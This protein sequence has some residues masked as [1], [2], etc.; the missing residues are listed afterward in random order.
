VDIRHQLKQVLREC[1]AR[2]LYHSG[3]HRLLDRLMPRRLLVLAGHCV[4]TPENASLGP[5]MRIGAAK[6]ERILSWFAARYEVL[7]LGRA[8]ERLEQPGR[9]S[10]VA[11]TMDDGYRDNRTQLLPLLQRL[12]LSATVYLES[13]PLEERRP[14]WTHKF[15][16]T[17]ERTGAERYAQLFTERSGLA[18]GANLSAYQLKRALKYEAPVALRTRI[19]DELFREQ[20]GD[21]RAL[22]EQLYLDWSQVRE[23]DRAGIEIGAHTHSHEILARLEPSEAR[24]EIAGSKEHLERGLGHPLK[25]FAYPFGRRWDYH[26]AAKDGAREAGFASATTT[27]AG[28]N[29]AGADRYELR[30]VMIAEDTRLYRLVAEACGGFDLLRRFGIELGE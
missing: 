22:C 18:L 5:N 8:L 27:H 26:A 15:A 20:G 9:R 13:A 14:N 28:T 19:V 25:S 10:L 1:Y 2:C 11:L 6:L 29:R 16:W 4:A 7:D 17:L 30:R 12:K 24:R 23:L 21:E 3:A